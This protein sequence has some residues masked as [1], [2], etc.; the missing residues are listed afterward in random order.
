LQTLQ[1]RLLEGRLFGNEDRANSLPVVII[2]ETFKKQYWPNE[3]PL[4][5][6]LQRSGDNTPWQTIIGVVAD[7]RERGLELDM[8]PAVYLPVVQLPFGSNNPQRSPCAPR[9]IRTP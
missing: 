6:H 5:K 3:S 1:A 2:N 7:G 9:W 8:K 4:G